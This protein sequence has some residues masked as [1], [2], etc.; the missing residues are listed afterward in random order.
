MFLFCFAL[1]AVFVGFG[2]FV[3][4]VDPL[5]EQFQLL[6]VASRAQTLAGLAPT[7]RVAVHAQ[8]AV[9]SLDGAQQSLLE[10]GHHQEFSS[11]LLASCSLKPLFPQCS[12]ALQQ[13]SKLQLGSGGI[14]ALQNYGHHLALGEFLANS[15]Q[16]F[17]KTSHQHRIQIG[18][19]P[20]GNPAAEARWIEESAND[21]PASLTERVEQ[22]GSAVDELFGPDTDAEEVMEE[23]VEKI[24]K[25]AADSE[26]DFMCSPCEEAPMRIPSNPSDPTLEEREKHCTT[27]IPY[28]SWCPV[29]VQ[30][31]AREDKHYKETSEEREL[32]L[33]RVSMDYAHADGAKEDVH[34]KR[35]LIGRDRWTSSTFVYLVKCKGLGDEGIVKKVTKAVDGLG[36]RKMRIK[37]DG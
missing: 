9:K 34:K 3:V 16:I 12:V 14:Q 13:A 18:F 23:D 26:P 17:F 8:G 32:D 35:L 2:P 7:Q 29:C 6:G 27:H 25:D 19:V 4:T 10:V 20:D 37:T 24:E 36:Y 15:A 30:A 33:P 21:E 28:R 5:L 11:A 31:R 22:D 1:H